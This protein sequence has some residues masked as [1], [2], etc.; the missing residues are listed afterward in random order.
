MPVITINGPIGCGSVI[1]GQMVAEKLGVDFV[2]RLVLTEA[3]KLVRA[4]VGALIDKEQRAVRFRKRLGRFMQDMLERSA[5]S[6]EMYSGGAFTTFPPEAFDALASGSSSHR[7]RVTDKEFID[8]TTAVVNKLCQA[9]DVVIIGRGANVIL[10]DTPG[11]LHVGL[12]APQ[13][14]RAKTMMQY[15]QLELEEAEVYVEELERAN[16]FYF[17]K[18][19]KVNPN[20]PSLYHTILNMGKL[21]PATAAE[22][23]IQAAE[24]VMLALP[25]PEDASLGAAELF[26]GWGEQGKQ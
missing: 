18:F 13:E 22:I 16:V 6:G 3:A 8:A 17:R 4:P 10:A 14:I 23:I 2:D 25:S 15:E 7:S 26:G 19:F 9:G 20:D 21:Q 12:I 11:V 24:D 1:I 5:M